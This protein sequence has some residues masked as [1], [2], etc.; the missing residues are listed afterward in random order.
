MKILLTG[1]SGMVGRNIL[2]HPSV[3]FHEILSPSRTE[4]NLLDVSN[5]KKYIEAN[6]PDMVI[7][8]AGI[9]GGI[10]ANMRQPVKFLVDNF[11][12]GI[13]ILLSCKTS[14]IKNFINISSS[15]IYPREAEN[16]LIEELILKGEFEP[17][18]EAFAIAKV[19]VIKLCEYISLENE[20]NLYKSVIS[21]NLY[22]KFDKFDKANS[23]MVPSV[24]KK[25]SEA[26]EQKKKSV[27][28]WGDGF[29]KREFMYAGDFADFIYYSIDNF[30]RMPQLINVGLGHDYSINEYYEKIAE[31]LNFKGEFA[32]DL[33]KPI[34]MKRKLLD[35]SKLKQ[36]G[37]HYKTSLI[38]GIRETYEY[39]I[40]EVGS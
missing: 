6:H 2:E 20:S 22:G 5:I 37:W 4:L 28:I 33:S 8:A 16:P 11:Q 23:H 27:D 21:C 34:G 32:H 15:C 24:I 30:D 3:R 29:A 17:T 13:N 10:Q 40:N 19:A 35:D 7:H 39:Y 14:G 9:V 25:I 18:N 12:M 38:D 1:A 26:K 31:V 36:F